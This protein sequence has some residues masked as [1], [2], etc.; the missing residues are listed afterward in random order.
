MDDE[1]TESEMWA[2]YRGNNQKK[3]WDNYKQSIEILQKKGIPFE[4]MKNES[5]L[6][7]MGD[8]DFW[9]STGKFINNR[10][11]IKG[12]GIFNLINQL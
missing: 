2:E 1:P 12:R 11:K 5:H 6:K 4:V 8:W 3:R 9:P 10:L 7:V